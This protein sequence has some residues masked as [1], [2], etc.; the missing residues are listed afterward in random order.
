MSQIR[1]FACP[2]THHGILLGVL[3]VSSWIQQRWL[4]LVEVAAGQWAVLISAFVDRKKFVTVATVNLS[5]HL[6]LQVSIPQTPAMTRVPE[7]CEAILSLLGAGGIHEA[8][9]SLPRSATGVPV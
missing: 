8:N 7:L 6:S 5:L 3:V 4:E 1:N 2:D 9:V